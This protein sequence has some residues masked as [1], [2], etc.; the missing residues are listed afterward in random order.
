MT[1]ELFTRSLSRACSYILHLVLGFLC[2]GCLIV[3]HVCLWY[4]KCCCGDLATLV[5][6]TAAT[7]SAREGAGRVCVQ[8][9]CPGGVNLFL[10]GF[11]PL[12]LAK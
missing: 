3:S 11:C 12:A 2:M 7:G 5:L 6:Y 1:E 8:M 4:V 9:K 10:V